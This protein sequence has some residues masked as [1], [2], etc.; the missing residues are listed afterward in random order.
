MI[1]LLELPWIKSLKAAN[2]SIEP[3]G[4]SKG[5]VG[6][7]TRAG[8]KFILLCDVM[9]Q[10]CLMLENKFVGIN[11]ERLN[12]VYQSGVRLSRDKLSL[13][14]DF[15]H[16]EPKLALRL[17]SGCSA[18][19]ASLELRNSLEPLSA[20]IE[21]LIPATVAMGI[22]QESANWYEEIKTNV[23]V[24]CTTKKGCLSVFCFG[25]KQVVQLPVNQSF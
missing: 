4:K 25:I 15:V 14:S 24:K 22:L 12:T 17:F 18:F 21:A 11:L 7:S 16:R 20:W 2:D 13:K 23:N 9:R 10:E 6:L 5:G 3:N 1:I 19:S 8:S